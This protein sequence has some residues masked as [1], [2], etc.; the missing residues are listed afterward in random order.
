MVVL[1]RQGWLGR[2][3]FVDSR[4]EGLVDRIDD[5]ESRGAK[6]LEQLPLDH[7]DALDHRGSVDRRRI[8]VRET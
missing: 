3:G 2:D 7:V 1:G 8:D 5:L 6:R 4:I